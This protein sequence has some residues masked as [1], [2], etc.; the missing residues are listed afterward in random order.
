M[1]INL[2][3]EDK[4]LIEKRLQ[5]G[6]FAGA[7]EVI[8][9]ALES[10]EAE[11]D[12]LQENRA[13]IS[14]NIERGLA[15]PERGEGRIPGSS[16]SQ[17]NGLANFW[18][19]KAPA[20]V[21]RC[22][23][24]NETVLRWPTL[25]FGLL[26]S[27]ALQAQIQQLAT[28]GDGGI[29]LVHTGFRLQPETDL[30]PQGK[31]YQWQNGEWKRL[32]AAPDNGFPF[33]PPDVFGPLIS[34]SAQ[35]IGWQINVGCGLCRIIVA[36]PLSSEIT[37]V[38]LPAAFPRGTLRMSRNGRYF[39]ADSYPFGG[40]KYVDADTG[41]MADVPVDLFARPVV[42]EPADDG[43][44]LL[45]ITQP[46]DPQ[47]ISAPGVLALWKPGSDPQPIYSEN[48]AQSPIISANGASVAFESVVEGGPDDD[49]RTLVVLDTHT[50]EEIPIAAMPAKDF[51]AQTVSFSMPAWD[52]AGT[53]LVY[54]T[55]DQQAQPS[56][57][58]LWDAASR[59]SRTLLTN[60]E[61]FAGAI[62]S[63]DGRIVWAVTQVSRLFR[64]D[65]ATGQTDEVLSPLG[66]G[67]ADSDAV[68]GSALLIRGTGFTK[69]QTAYDGDV[70]LPLVDVTAEGYWLQIPWED[71]SVPEG[72]RTLHIRS[73][74]NPFE[75]V[76]RVFLAHRIETHIALW[77]DPDTGKTYAKA[78]H[79]DFQSLVTPSSPARPGETV[80]IYI[81]GMG[82]LDLPVP[83]GAPGPS[84]PPAH[85]LAPLTCSIGNDD[86]QTLAIPFVGY[87]A[88]MIG[89]YQADLTIPDAPPEGESLLICTAPD[90]GGTY[91]SSALLSTTTESAPV[92]AI[93]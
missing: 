7:E 43:T 30:G 59:Q 8:H 49:R 47:Q 86:R 31:I 5:S 91:G 46:N 19:D 60:D 38:T 92:G 82:P 15:Q 77:T 37:G 32:A 17:E 10:L 88:G 56:G 16:R 4:K 85:P 1:N 27:T 58:A 22:S 9:R 24:Y 35:V 90:P 79:Q 72:S 61:G 52:A 48:H 14:S 71:A 3:P 25:V 87:A 23:S 55:F 21:R 13:A 11:E 73:D 41:E 70:P 51:R 63:D 6:T 18:I 66:S 69:N 65:L 39:T 2:T 57:I 33:S 26:V 36:P 93:R 76:V 78:V 34:T 68:P 42:R 83:T 50:G 45:L 29:L 12:W 67:G 74:N 44:V 28:S 89:I 80:H 64:L 54:R 84:D 53:K 20:T 40:A 81:T 62:L 75:S